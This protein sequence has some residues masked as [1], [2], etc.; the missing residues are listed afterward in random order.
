M[1]PGEEVA[2]SRATCPFSPSLAALQFTEPSVISAFRKVGSTVTSTPHFLLH[3][4]LHHESRCPSI[5]LCAVFVFSVAHAARRNSRACLRLRLARLQV[6]C[7]RSVA[8]RFTPTHTKN[9]YQTEL[10]GCTITFGYLQKVRDG[11]FGTSA[12]V[13]RMLFSIS[14]DDNIVCHAGGHQ[15]TFPSR[16]Q[17]RPTNINNLGSPP[18]T[19]GIT[20]QM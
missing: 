8:C 12:A 17:Q 1:A 15:R 7:L 18:P 5:A 11:V 19:S 10:L 20:Q 2:I 6:S 3:Q 13:C 16:M 14:A 4:Q 9:L